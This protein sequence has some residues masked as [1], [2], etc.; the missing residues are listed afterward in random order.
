MP[1]AFGAAF[2]H[3][4]SAQKISRAYARHHRCGKFCHLLMRIG[5]SKIQGSGELHQIAQINGST[6]TAPGI[7][8]AKS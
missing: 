6:V 7:W 3:A 5:G 4:N 8:L 2:E 1:S